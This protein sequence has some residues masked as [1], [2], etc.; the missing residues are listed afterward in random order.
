MDNLPNKIKYNKANFASKRGSYQKYTIAN[1][2]FKDIVEEALTLKE[3]RKDFL[4]FVATKYG[5]RERTL[6]RKINKLKK[7]E[8]VTT[9]LRGKH[10]AS[11]TID[12][13]REIAKK[14][15][16]DYIDKG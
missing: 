9:D 2:N 8:D 1:W 4:K 11:F 15:K 13:E 10:T 16:T 7:G 12:Q 14:I 3:T 6:S 5:V